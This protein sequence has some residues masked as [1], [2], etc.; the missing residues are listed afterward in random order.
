LA[1]GELGA[2]AEE[3]GP[4]IQPALSFFW[5]QSD[6]INRAH[7]GSSRRFHRRRAVTAHLLDAVFGPAFSVAE[8]AW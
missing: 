7:A 4:A 1:V 3:K 2:H 8:K 6:E 5:R